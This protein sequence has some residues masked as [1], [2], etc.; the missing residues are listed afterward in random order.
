ENLNQSLVPTENKEQSLV[1]ENEAK[2]EQIIREGKKPKAWLK[3]LAGSAGFVAGVGLSV[4]AGSVPILGTAITI[5]TTARLVYN[6]SKGINNIVTRHR[7]KK[8]TK[9]L[10][11]QINDLTAIEPRTPEQ[12]QQLIDNISEYKHIQ[13]CLEKKNMA[14]LKANP[15]IK[16]KITQV[17]EKNPKIAKVAK[18]I[19]DK[20]KNPY[21]K[22][23]VNGASLGYLV[24]NMLNVKDM[25]ESPQGRETSVT[26]SSGQAQENPIT[27]PVPEI[28]D[29]PEV[30][31]TYD[32]SEVVNGYISSDSTEPLHMLH[33]IGEDRAI[34]TASKVVD[35]R[36]MVHFA[37]PDGDGYAWF[38]WDEIKNIIKEVAT[39][40]R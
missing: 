18:V 9:K 4:A 33:Q 7:A 32:L 10:E 22:W 29:M 14:E 19:F 25:L 34:I 27:T 3:A 5:Y 17:K 37:T 23:F 38:P 6:A 11:Q 16:T 24:G 28:S 21:A 12:E 15:N 1:P 36:Q 26:P 31:Q 40:A 2:Q 35:G 30:G 20:P 39:K 13:H 8:Q